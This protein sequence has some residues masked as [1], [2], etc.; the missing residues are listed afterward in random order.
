MIN[1]FLMIRVVMVVQEF[2]V[3]SHYVLNSLTFQQLFSWLLKRGYIYNKEQ[4]SRKEF[5]KRAGICRWPTTVGLR[6]TIIWSCST[7]VGHA[8]LDGHLSQITTGRL[9]QL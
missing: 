4:N 9:T 7:A 1:A 6:T 2:L 5:E 8:F 3:Y